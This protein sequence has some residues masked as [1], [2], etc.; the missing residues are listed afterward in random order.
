MNSDEQKLF[1]AH[2]SEDGERKQTVLAHLKNTAILAARFAIPFHAEKQA[3]LA[4]LVHDLG[5]YSDAFQ[6]RLMGDPER[7]DH[8]TAG[9]KEAFFMV[10]PEVAFAVAGHHAGMPD[11]GSKGD[12]AQSPTLLGRMRKATEPC[13]AWENELH[14]PEA[15]PPG[16]L[17]ADS[18]TRSFYIRM[19]FSCLV[20]AD[21]LDTE[22][23]MKGGP[24]CRGGYR[25]MPRLLKKLKK[26]V[27][28]WWEAKTELNRQR[29]DILRTC[30]E[31]GRTGEKGLY[32]LTVPT[33]GGKTVSSLAFALSL[34]CEQEMDRVIFVV[35]YTSIIDQTAEKYAEILGKDNVLEHHS[36]VDYT[37]GENGRGDNKKALA[38]E[39]WD[40]PVIVTTA[41]QFFE[42]LYANRPS[43]CRKLHNISNSVVVF[44]EAQT[45]PTPYLL[46]C[47]AAIAQLVKH[48][49]ATAVLCTA[50]QPALGPIF[51]KLAPDLQMK[52]ICDEPRRLYETFRRTELQ[53]LGELITEA[54][55][56]RLAASPQALCVV[57]RRKTAQELYRTLAKEG[58][59]CLTTLL[60]PKHR[61]KLLK[62]IRERLTQGLPC[63][64]VSTS[65]IEAG[66]DVDFPVAYREET[67]LDSIL[68]TAGRCNREGRRTADESTVFIFRL[69]GQAPIKM[70]SQN[71]ESLRNVLRDFADPTGLDAIERYFTFFRTLLGE[72]AL[73]EQ[74]IIEG[75]TRGIAN[76]VFPFATLAGRFQLI[77][78][79]TQPVYIPLERGKNL[80]DR[81]RRGE[82]SRDLFRQ[83]GQYSVNIYPQHLKALDSAGKLEWIDENTPVLAD[84]K[85]YDP[86]TG[87]AMDVETGNAFFA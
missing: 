24:A 29:C 3:Y 57:N 30:F 18:F 22:T 45:I 84:T 46:P 48:Y 9:A 16:K 23:F 42:S 74:R 75:F 52:E 80:I 37:I 70:L 32:T 63:R 44:D 4:G 21:Y 78:N 51:E 79:T 40:A 35:P 67:G 25:A 31:R 69:A 68:Q 87:L 72:D 76:G 15:H 36:G 26:Y 73:D 43:K 47:T 50:T 28:P 13:D 34:A 1:Y 5:K 77:G 85:C 66:V 20:D 55:T 71:I 61:K 59:Y 58:S 11:G 6:R 17:P 81:L 2:I 38:A 86:H 19:L 8:S 12:P 64:V 33:G 54:L 27:E 60:Y 14:L 56:Q 82:R 10:Q 41:V 7:V 49:G 62:E 65:L 53:N 83:L 39:N